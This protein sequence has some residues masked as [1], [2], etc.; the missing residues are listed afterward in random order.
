MKYLHAYILNN[1]IIGEDK[2]SWREDDL[3]GNISFIISNNIYESNYH[4]IT[5]IE[6]WNNYGIISGCDHMQVKQGIVGILEEITWS[7]LT[8]IEKDITI[9]YFAY[10]DEI[11][12]FLYLVYEKGM[13]FDDAK[14]Y[15]V[16]SWHSHH[17]LLIDCYRE[18]WYQVKLIVATYLSFADAQDLFNHANLLIYSYTEA[19]IVGKNYNDNIDGLLDFIESTNGYTNNGLREKQYNVYNNDW[20]IFINKLK[21]ILVYG[22]Y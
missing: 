14:K 10:Q 13:S 20:D 15:L 9:N 17:K 11:D 22:N 12:P 2:K 21:D 18:R 5:S 1:Q 16:K 6:N 4:N 7:S 3:N 19:G 8:S